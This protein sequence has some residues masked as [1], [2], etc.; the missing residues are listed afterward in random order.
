MLCDKLE[1]KAVVA[2]GAVP[3]H[4]NSMKKKRWRF[5]KCQELNEE[6]WKL[7]RVEVTVDPVGFR[8]LGSVTPKLEK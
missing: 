5:E 7:R 3:G 4:C 2:D 1:K 6:I 8:T